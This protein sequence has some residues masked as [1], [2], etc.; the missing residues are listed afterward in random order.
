MDVRLEERV[1][2]PDIATIADEHDGLLC[3]ELDSQCVTLR[4]A[5]IRDS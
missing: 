2:L 1:R 4:A 5:T 3:A